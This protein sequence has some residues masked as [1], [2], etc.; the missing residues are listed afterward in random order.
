MRVRV[1]IPFLALAV[2]LFLVHDGVAQQVKG[3]QAKVKVAGPTRI[4]WTFAATNRSLDKVPANLLPADYDS[5]KQQYD[6]FVPP[7]YNAK[8]SYPVVIFINAGEGPAGWPHWEPAC[9]QHGII[10]ASP[11]GAGNNVDMPK[12]IRIVL[13][14]LDD[15]R[16]NYNTDPDRTYTSGY[17]G[18]GRVAGRIAFSLPEYFGGT[19][20]V[21]ATGEF[22]NETW[23]QHRLIDR[24][25]V[26]L[27]T[28]ESDFNRGECER[29]MSAWM[30][31]IGVRTKTWVVPKMGHGIPSGATFGEVFTWLEEDLPRR[32]ELAKKYPASQVPGNAAPPRAELAAAVLAEGKQRLQAKETTY[33]GVMLLLGCAIRW[34]DVPAGA[35][36]A[37]LVKEY[38]A[39]TDKYWDEEHNDY[40]RRFALGQARGLYAYASG[41]LAGEY[42]K[43]RPAMAKAALELYGRLL[44]DGKDAKAVEEAKKRIPELEKLLKQ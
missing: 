8:Q 20:P 15:V 6:L 22:R 38:D 21:C 13:D 25:S 34:G 11:Y 30:T 37:K 17:S 28:G 12:R 23:L 16:R 9:K 4:D 26:A 27:V 18:G 33:R 41:P 29:Y 3:F 10:F 31:E 35:E 42:A 44:Q 2:G 39:K 7:T 32:R 5:G 24:V 19:V 1:V 36:A 14:V 40:E 43:Q